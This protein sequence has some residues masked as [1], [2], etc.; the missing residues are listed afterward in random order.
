MGKRCL[1]EALYIGR[2]GSQGRAGLPDLNEGVGVDAPVF[3]VRRTSGALPEV[4]AL[5]TSTRLDPSNTRF[6]S[7]STG[8]L[9]ITI[10][11][12]MSQPAVRY[13]V[14]GNKACT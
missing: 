14:S 5:W 11:D 10:T 3:M 13:S 2:G 12:P 7:F 9:R 8:F 1:L 4:Q 6:P